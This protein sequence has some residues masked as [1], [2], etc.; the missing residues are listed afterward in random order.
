MDIHK[1]EI[2]LI[3]A[4]FILF[5]FKIIFTIIFDRK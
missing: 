3:T 1:V 2:L 4:G 5:L